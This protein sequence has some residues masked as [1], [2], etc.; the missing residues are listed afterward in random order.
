[1]TFVHGVDVASYQGPSPDYS[2]CDFVCIKVT[3]GTWYVSPVWQQQL[4][5]A[6]ADGLVV[7]FSHFPEA[8]Q[9]IPAQVAF[10]RAT[11]ADQLLPGDL[12]QLDW[13]TD[14]AT[15]T[16]PDCVQKDALLAAMSQT[17]P[18]HKVVLYC[19]LD[20]WRTVD[21]TSDCADGLWIADP[22]SP[23]GQPAVRHPWLI[24]QY[25]ISGDLDQDVAA[26]STRAAFAAWAGVP[27]SSPTPPPPEVDMTPE[28]ATQLN[29][30]AAAVTD[31]KTQLA[32]LPAAVWH[33][34]ITD[35]PEAHA[36]PGTAWSAA[37]YLA[38]AT[39]LAEVKQDMAAVRGQLTDLA[40][41]VSRLAAALGKQ[42]PA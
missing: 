27:G 16:A 19:N 5:E 38:H 11:V 1:V 34:D 9:D 10:M 14:P 32:G 26:F 18:G 20:F 4:A 21:T 17:F 12:V 42:T 41:E 2:G 24:H 29:N 15:G 35:P 36:R 37:A 22:S 25:D 33:A 6:R 30:V 31:I 40:A 39:D 3:Q 23:P 13:E 8:A 7:L 28:Q